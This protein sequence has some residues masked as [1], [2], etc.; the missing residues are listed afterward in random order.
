MYVDIISRLMAEKGHEVKVFVRDTE[1]RI[2]RVNERLSYVRFEASGNRSRAYGRLGYWTALSYQYY[3]VVRK[4]AEQEGEPDIIEAQEYN[5]PAYYILQYKLLDEKFLKDTRIVVHLHTPTFELVRINRDSE[6]AFPTYWIGRMEKFCIEGADGLVIPSEFLKKFIQKEFPDKEITVIPQPFECEE[7]VSYECGNYLLYTGRLEYRKGIMQFIEQMAHLWEKGNRTKLVTIGGDTFFSPKD[8]N[9]GEIIKEKYQKWIEE[10]LLEING[11]IPPS[12]LNRRIVK[13]RGIVVPSIYENFPYTCLEAMWQGCPMLVSK[14]GGQSEMTGEDGSRGI[15]FDWEKEGDCAEKIEKFL[16]LTDEELRQM[17]E[18][19]KKYIRQ[20]CGPDENVRK[21]EAFFR[22]VM[23][24]KERKTFPVLN[25]QRVTSLPEHVDKGERGLLSV[26]ICYYNLGNTVMETMESLAKI[27]YENYETI[28]INDGS[29]D[30]G[31]LE[32]LE[33]IRERYPKVRIE[34]IPN[35]GLANARNVGSRLAR[36]EYIS[37]LD[38]DDKV[39]PDY[40]RRCIEVLEQ[41]E[42]VSFVYSWL[43]Y[44]EGSDGVWTTFNTELP[45][46]LMGN[47]L[48]AFAVVR[49]ADFVCFG[50]NRKAVEYGMEDY[51]GW[52]GMVQNGRNGVCIPEPLCYYRVRKDSMTR[53]MAFSAKMYLYKTMEEKH[54]A[55]YERYGADIYNLTNA[56]GP[57]YLWGNQT[58]VQP[59]V[60]HIVE[61]PIKEEAVG[62][63]VEDSLAYE[64]LKQE[65]CVLKSDLEIIRASKFYKMHLVY[66]R[67]LNSLPLV[68]KIRRPREY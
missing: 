40:Y 23:G 49:K 53:V 1:D 35:G 62:M 14:Q 67:I 57:G 50:Q 65:N 39:S 25:A 54:H 44:F 3:E 26:I 30:P 46:M 5:A 17:G 36:G 28:I 8:R 34:N 10:G 58:W 37:F 64:Q 59:R 12:E 4:Y 6:Y 55:L 56:N 16:R 20:L 41:Y 15:V 66:E 13:A 7:E 45:Y 38:A 32:K 68:K 9:L 31:S 48:S 27:D 42:N 63:E 18:N 2:E 29:T 43:Q 60:G 61:T 21:R 19:G 51:D 47:M 11:A 52:L 22:E 33:E 24:R